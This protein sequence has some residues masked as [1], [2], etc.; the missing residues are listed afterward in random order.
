MTG[1]RKKPT[2]IFD[3][4]GDVQKIECHSFYTERCAKNCKSLYK[5]DKQW[6]CHYTNDI[7]PISKEG[8]LMRTDRCLES[9]QKYEESLCLI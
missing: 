1:P 8:H 2:F 9:E 6:Y 5:Y 3:R 4:Q 7:I